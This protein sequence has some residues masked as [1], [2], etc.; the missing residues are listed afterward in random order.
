[1][2]E[3][4]NAVK[5]VVAALLFED[6]LIG[7][8]LSN[9][10]GW[11]DIDIDESLVGI[12]SEMSLYLNHANHFQE[13]FTILYES[14][15]NSNFFEHTYIPDSEPLADYIYNISLN[16]DFEWIETSQVGTNLCLTDDT[17]TRIDLP[18]D[19]NFYG[20]TY[21][22]ITVSSNGWIALGRTDLLSF[23]NYP[24]PGAGGPA[25]MIAA[26][27]LFSFKLRPAPTNVELYKCSSVEAT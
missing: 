5:D 12:G 3:D 18:F 10:D 9:N 26:F 19:F 8:D 16:E 4:G 20:D 14:D 7:K 21:N 2:D 22:Q 27:S 13:K 17:V 11:I 24:I 15:E 23:R 1:M 25:P 6:S